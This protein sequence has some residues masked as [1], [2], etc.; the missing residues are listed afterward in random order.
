[1]IEFEC[2]SCQ[3]RARVADDQAGTQVK[4][5][6]CAVLLEIP[7]LDSF[8]ESP[9]NT[10]RYRAAGYEAIGGPVGP[11]PGATGAA[12]PKTQKGADELPSCA[13]HSDRGARQTCPRC[14]DF[15]CPPCA[16]ESRDGLCRT[17]QRSGSIAGFP[18]GPGRWSL[19][20]L[21][22]HSWD[23]YKRDA[24]VLTVSMIG[25]WFASQILTQGLSLLAPAFGTSGI[26]LTVLISLL[27]GVI[28]VVINVGI[29]GMVMRSL[30]AR[31]ISFGHI[32]SAFGR[33]LSILWT[34]LLVSCVIM[35]AL[36]VV[37]VLAALIIPVATGI[38]N[39][40]IGVAVVLGC[41]AVVISIWFFLPLTFLYHELAL[42]S[43][44]SGLETI[45]NCYQVV[46]GNR[47]TAIGIML[48]SSLMNMAGA[49][50]CG[51]GLI[52]TM[53]LSMIWL[54]ALYLALRQESELEPFEL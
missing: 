11:T 17:C 5:G 49:M 9:P 40:G 34:L 26:V 15:L 22:D 42:N 41:V 14:G 44:S 19:A 52:V 7:R 2:P 6:S 53:P 48:L 20:E 37:G 18:F 31:R 33:T 51:L 28:S 29:V 10:E 21:L 4:C 45:K 25:T 35:G 27:V 16:G 1:M 24:V 8:A 54:S 47:G 30:T 43:R 36:F 39:A 50:L 32:L 13:H 23:C 12:P 3:S 38:G 46:S